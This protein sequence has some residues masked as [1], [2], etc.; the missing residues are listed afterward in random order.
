[1]SDKTTRELQLEEALRLGRD[2]RAT[3]RE[4]F[5]TRDRG[6]MVD[7]KAKEA[8]FDRAVTDLIGARDAG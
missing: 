2:M 8:A 3:Q 6:L 1:M 4:F 7:A 5:R